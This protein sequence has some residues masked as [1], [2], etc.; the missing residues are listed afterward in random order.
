VLKRTFL[1]FTTLA[2]VSLTASAL[3]TAQLQTLKTAILADPV[4]AAKPM[5]STGASQIADAFNLQASPAFTVWR[6]SVTKAEVQSSSAF[7][8]TRVDNLSVGKARIW[9]SMFYAGSINPSQANVRAG[10]DATWVG[11]QADLNVRAAVY[12]VC[13]RLA[14]RGEKLYAVGTGSDAVPATMAVEGQ[15]T[16]DDVQQARELP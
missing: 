8:W 10:I 16:S 15:I 1:L 12:V 14:T 6:T 9:D 4:L 3:T 5:T 13:K 11:T 7:D 2:A